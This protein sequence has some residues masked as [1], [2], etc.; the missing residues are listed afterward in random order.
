MRHFD[1]GTKRAVA[2]LRFRADGGGVTASFRATNH[3][4]TWDIAGGEA[5]RTGPVAGQAVTCFAYSPDG[6]VLAVGGADG[7]A[8]AYLLPEVHRLRELP[9]GAASPGVDAQPVHG[10]AFSPHPD[11]G[12]QWLAACGA[13]VWLW[14]RV[15]HEHVCLPDAGNYTGVSFGPDGATVFANVAGRSLDGWSLK[16]LHEWSRLPITNGTLSQFAVAP[17]GE[18]VALRALGPIEIRTFGGEVVHRLLL[19][20]MYRPTDLTYTPDG[21]LLLVASGS[22][23]V[24]ACDPAT[25]QVAREYDWGVGKV[26]AVAVSPDGTM[27]AA[28]GEKGQV[29]VWDLD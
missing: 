4:V 21:R 19:S 10:V 22:F 1:A 23:P 16:P 28:G 6:E 24:F 18:T 26:T 3:L 13:E 2:Q 7:V 17:D 15:T 5:Q 25:G 20:S 12:R 14:N 9:V 27:A 11:P 29:V 8:R